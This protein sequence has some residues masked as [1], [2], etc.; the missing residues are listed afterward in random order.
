MNPILKSHI[1]VL[2]HRLFREM[3]IKFRSSPMASTSLAGPVKTKLK[4]VQ[5]SLVK[6][7][8]TRFNQNP[9]SRR[10]AIHIPALI[11]NSHSKT[12]KCTKVKIIYFC[13]QNP[14]ELRHD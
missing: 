6:T 1:N 10:N 12:N 4:F 3:F 11:I 7:P 2:S 14:S 13:T 9:L 5:Q 8:N